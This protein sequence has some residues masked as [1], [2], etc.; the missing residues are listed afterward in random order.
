MLSY[1]LKYRENQE[2][3]KIEEL[4]REIKLMLSSKHAMCDSKKS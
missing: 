4:Q 2:S 1:R 3:K